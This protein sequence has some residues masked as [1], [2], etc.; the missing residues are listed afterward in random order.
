MSF[1]ILK[2]RERERRQ[3]FCKM[4][5]KKENEIKIKK[6]EI[7]K[8]EMRSLKVVNIDKLKMCLMLFI[9][10]SPPD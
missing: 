9:D 5:Q 10:N 2:K 3:C 6:T 1:Y 8:G 7:N 4:G